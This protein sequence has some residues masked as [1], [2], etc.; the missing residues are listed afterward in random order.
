M[1][2]SVRLWPHDAFISVPLESARRDSPCQVHAC[3]RLTASS[4]WV[5]GKAAV[6]RDVLPLPGDL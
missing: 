4:K 3:S 1:F 6:L 2:G 5:M